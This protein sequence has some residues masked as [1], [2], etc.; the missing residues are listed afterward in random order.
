MDGQL[1]VMVTG[2]MVVVW[3]ILNT[4]LTR[5]LQAKLSA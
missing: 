4:N 1:V 2:V 3:L 5:D